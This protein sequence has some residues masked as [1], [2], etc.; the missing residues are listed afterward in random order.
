M[1][2]FYPVC[3]RMKYIPPTWRRVMTMTS[4][5]LMY[6]RCESVN[7]LQYSCGILHL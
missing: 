5:H 4:L 6:N 2:A 7:W 1:T 3:V